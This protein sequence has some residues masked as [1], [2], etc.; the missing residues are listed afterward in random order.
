[1][2]L[3]WGHINCTQFSGSGI[4]AI[5]GHDP[6]VEGEWEGHFQDEWEA[7]KEIR[8][9][10]FETLDDVI[11]DLFPE[12]P[13]AFVMPGDVVLIKSAAW[14][15][16]SRIVMPHGVALADPPFFYAVTPEGL[17]RG[18]LYSDGVRG[19]AVGRSI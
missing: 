16:E 9:R 18:D 19:F 8:R 17:G 3:D 14:D 11:A 6:Y 1:M 2:K 12:I 10:G 5:T 7:G 4:E 15:G 13:L